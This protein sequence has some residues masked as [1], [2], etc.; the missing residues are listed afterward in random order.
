MAKIVDRTREALEAGETGLLLMG[1]TRPV[2]RKKE[3]RKAPASV[4][5]RLADHLSNCAVCFKPTDRGKP[6]AARMCGEGRALC[7]EWFRAEGWK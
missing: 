4:Y 3:R 1:A 2:Q 5:R 6:P 7:A